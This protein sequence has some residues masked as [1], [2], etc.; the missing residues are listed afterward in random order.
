AE[1]AA[2]EKAAAEKAAAEKAAAEKAAAEK[3][4]AEKAAAEKAAA[5]KAAA[6]KAAAEKAAAEKAAAEKAAAE[7][8]AAEKAAAE[9]A[10]AE[11]AAAEKA[12]AEKAAAEKAAAIEANRLVLL[13]KAK[14]AGLNDQQAAAYAED[15]KEADEMSAQTALESILV[16]SERIALDEALYQAKDKYHNNNAYPIGQI[17]AKKLSHSDVT[18]NGD[19]TIRIKH[20]VVYNQPYS[21]VLGDYSSWTTG[22][23]SYIFNSGMDSSITIKGLKTEVSAIPFLGT[24]NYSGKAFSSE[25]NPIFASTSG[26]YQEGLLSYDVNFTDKTGVGSITGLGDVISLNQGSISGTGI[27][28][29][30]KQ[31]TNTGTYSLDFYG[32]KAEEIAGKVIFNGKDTVGF[33]GTRGEI[34]K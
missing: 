8:A 30:A 9:K 20:E 33:G 13:N 11:K 27:T 16:E 22:V 32:K 15:N 18:T 7:K 29:T 23:G 5:E 6:E 17:T 14:E 10:A 34:T 25:K 1:K 2:A 24:A 28:S 21:V 12:A 26:L 3:A 19:R 31:L 4:A